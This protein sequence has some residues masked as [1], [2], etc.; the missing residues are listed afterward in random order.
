MHENTHEEDVY[1]TYNSIHQS[2]SLYIFAELPKID[3]KS[4]VC[5]LIGED[6]Y[7]IRNHSWLLA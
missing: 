4:Y 2:F 3:Q 5:K 7:S 6:S 1:F